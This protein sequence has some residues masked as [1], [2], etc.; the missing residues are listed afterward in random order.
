MRSNRRTR[1]RAKVWTAEVDRG[2]SGLIGRL[3]LAGVAALLI[4]AQA[5]RNAAVKALAKQQPESAAAFWQS[6]PD[7]EL[8]LAM[9]GIAKA[10]RDRELVNTGIFREVD[11]AAAKAP[12]D[13]QPFLVRGVQ[14]QLRSDRRS[15]EQAFVAA[16]RRDPRSVPAAF[17]LADHY[18]RA[19]DAT[20]GLNQVVI[21]A[22]LT[23]GGVHSVAPYVAAYASNRSNWPQIRRLFRAEPRLEDEALA[24]L[25]RNA[26]NADTI[27]ALADRRRSNAQSPWLPPLLANLVE[28]RQ[29]AKAKAVWT[30]ISR[31]PAVGGDLLYDARFSQPG[32]PA[33]FNWELTSSTVGL[34]ER[35]SEGRLHAIF[36]GQEDGV[37]ARQLLVLPPGSYR[38]SVQ[39][40]GNPKPLR[41]SVRCDKGSEVGRAA[42]EIVARSGWSFQVPAGCPAQ[43]LEL[44]GASSDM[45]QQSEVTISGLRLAREDGG[46]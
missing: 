39:L 43:W 9:V 44:A 6:H 12:L 45:P 11:S 18:F 40:S 1:T 19:G 10:M 3:L 32:P 22:R 27:L 46:A 38:L 35:Q 14:A 20:R 30:R 16:Q 7:V 31:V 29:Y 41:W 25:A 2:G 21:L 5:V 28:A 37:L 24:V 26:G 8:S 34:A 13:P 42:L 33:P 17:F 23:P 36:Y 15:A 4:G